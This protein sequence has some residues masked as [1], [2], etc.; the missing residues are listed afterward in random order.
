MSAICSSTNKSAFYKRLFNFPLWKHKCRRRKSVYF[1]DMRRVKDRQKRQNRTLYL[2]CA[3]KQLPSGGRITARRQTIY[4]AA[5]EAHHKTQHYKHND[6][7]LCP[8]HRDALRNV[9]SSQLSASGAWIMA[10]QQ[11]RT[12]WKLL[13]LSAA[14]SLRSVSLSTTREMGA[15]RSRR[16]AGNQ[17]RNHV[18][19]GG[20]L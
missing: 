14:L 5:V 20:G 17:F 3:Y 2:F 9:L 8:G 12:L 18:D 13:A 15:V 6:V 7:R 19:G 11:R 1:C 16:M 10:R 4:R